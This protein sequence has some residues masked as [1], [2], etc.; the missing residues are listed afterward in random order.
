CLTAGM[1]VLLEVGPGGTLRGMA[2]EIVGDRKAVALSTLKRGKGDWRSV[3]ET[4]AEL[5]S[6]GTGLEVANM[7]RGRK[8]RKTALP[9]YP[10]ERVRCWSGK[11]A[12]QSG[13]R[14]AAEGTQT[15]PFP[16]GF[17]RCEEEGAERAVYVSELDGARER[18]VRE[19]RV[20]GR[21]L[22]AGASYWDMA[23]RAVSR[24][25][26]EAVELREVVNKAPL[27]VGPLE[28]VTVRT[29]AE[30]VENEWRFRIESRGERGAWREHS[31]GKAVCSPR[32]EAKR[33]EVPRFLGQ[34]GMSGWSGEEVYRRLSEA[35]LEY[36]P[37]FRSIQRMEMYGNEAV[38]ELE[39]PEEAERGEGYAYAPGMVDG[40]LQALIGVMA[41]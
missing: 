34:E 7:Y 39:L 41:S 36:G 35:G 9:P 13:E 20:Q 10:F 27:E 8:E 4:A 40:A 38:V 21:S 22:V 6:R 29:I 26:D 15:A 18:L 30:R 17:D 31:S 14:G 5:Y 19:H 3:L 12:E 23:V 32:K 28:R 24:G 33:R 1:E 25:K 16:A 37:S 11:K 2:G